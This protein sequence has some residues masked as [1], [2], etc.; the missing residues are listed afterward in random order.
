MAA[1]RIPYEKLVQTF[2]AI[3]LDHKFNNRR[4]ELC[5]TLFAKASLDGVASHGLNRFPQFLELVKAG[6]VDPAAEPRL[7]DAFGSFERWDGRLGPGNL[8]AYH[9]MNRAIELARDGGIGCIAIRN[10]N[11]WMRGGNFGWQAV[12]NG[13]IGVCFTNT[14]PNMPA[15]GGSEAVLG[16]NPLVVAVP[17]E[18]SPVVLDMA[19]SQFSYGKISTYLREQRQLP[20]DGG[21]DSEG[22]LTKDPAS[23]LQEELALPIGLWKGAGLSLMLDILAALLS[24]GKPTCEIG[25]LEEEYAISQVFLC[26]YL[27]K[28]GVTRQ[29]EILEKIIENLKSSSVFGAAEVRYPG[30]QTLT[31]RRENSKKGV[32]V[33]K[34]IWETVLKM[35]ERAG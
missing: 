3:L 5:A 16:N 15:W 14:T 35:Q 8:N 7:L 26:F 29:D 22:N 11:H 20:Y 19:L 23:I 6:Y 21:F 27:P 31:N 30:E 24:D 10:T 4:A 12:E 33:D 17:R 32:P 1:I 18:E 28:L 9:C 13:C 25:K 34:Q 2:T